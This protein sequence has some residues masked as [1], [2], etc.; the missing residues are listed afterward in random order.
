MHKLDL[1]YPPP[2]QDSSGKMSR[3]RLGTPEPQ[4]MVH[5]ILGGE[6]GLPADRNKRGEI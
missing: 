4:K 6:E 3:F 1:L 5:A 2:T